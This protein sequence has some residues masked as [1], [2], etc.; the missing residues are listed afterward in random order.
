MSKAKE[1]FRAIGIESLFMLLEIVIAC[2]ATFVQTLLKQYVDDYS[3]FLWSGSNYQYNYFMYF[4][5]IVFWVGASIL[6]YKKFEGHI[7]KFSSMGLA[8]FILLF[9]LFI[10]GVVMCY[11]EFIVI[12]VMVLGLSNNLGPEALFLLTLIGWPL[13][14]V[15]FLAVKITIGKKTIE[16]K[17]M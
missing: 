10:W 15:V 9:V 5:G 17:S 13:I 4:L 16:D 8:K 14:T 2:I 7:M 6:L 11:S 3:S 1:I 12:F